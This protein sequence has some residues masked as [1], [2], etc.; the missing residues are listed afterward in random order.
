MEARMVGRTRVRTLQST[1]G[2]QAL[3]DSGADM[4]PKWFVDVDPE[5]GIA[6]TAYHPGGSY[7][8]VA[9]DEV[10][11]VRRFHAGEYCAGL[12]SPEDCRAS[13]GSFGTW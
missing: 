10:E 11:H 13:S 12:H 9:E 4:G 1:I 7:Y 5:T 3:I 6:F 2:P 8:A